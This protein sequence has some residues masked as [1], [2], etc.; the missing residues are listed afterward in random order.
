MTTKKKMGAGI[1]AIV[2]AIAGGSFAL[3]FSNTTNTDNSQSTII[4]EGD[5]I[6]NEAADTITDDIFDDL[7]DL[8]YDY[9]CEDYPDAEECEDYWG[10]E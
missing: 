3:D 7:V 9:F 10:D 5:T 8:G 6:I 4:N 1:F 2:V